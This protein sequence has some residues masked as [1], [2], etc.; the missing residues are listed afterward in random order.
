MRKDY[1]WLC[2]VI[3]AL[4]IS[5][6]CKK[7]DND[8]NGDPTTSYTVSDIDGNTYKVVEI[9]GRAWMVEDLRTTCFRDGEPIPHVPLQSEWRNLTS[10]A[11]CWYDND[12]LEPYSGFGLLYNGYAVQSG[13]LCPAGW[14]VP[15]D[16]E[17]QEL[18]AYLGIDSADLPRQGW[19]GSDQGGML[20]EKGTAHWN[21][22]NKEADNATGFTGL[23]GGYRNHIG[24][25]HNL[26]VDGSWWSQTTSGTTDN[27]WYR[28]L[29]FDTG[30]IGRFNQNPKSGFAVRC[31]RTE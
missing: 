23:P 12:T 28:R 9:G 8:K 21:A 15:T 7:E 25:F 17:W 1:I 31:I 20:K 14:H 3:A 5:I 26:G 16:E 19:R 22:P 13:L 24:L 10:V 18:E 4:L 29:A 30:G 2:F 11:Y 27:I 6:G